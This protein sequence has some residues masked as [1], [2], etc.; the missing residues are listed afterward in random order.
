MPPNILKL[1]NFQVKFGRQWPTLLAVA[2]WQKMIALIHADAEFVVADVD[3]C[4]YAS[5]FAIMF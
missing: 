2:L 4:I 3:V 1:N 5:Q